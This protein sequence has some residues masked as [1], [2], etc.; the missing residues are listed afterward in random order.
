MLGGGI[1]R[2]CAKAYANARKELI[3]ICSLPYVVLTLWLFISVSLVTEYGIG[4]QHSPPV[5]CALGLTC[6]WLLGCSENGRHKHRCHCSYV[7]QCE[8]LQYSVCLQATKVVSNGPS[9]GD[10][11][12][13]KPYPTSTGHTGIICNCLRPSAPF[14]Y[15]CPCMKEMGRRGPSVLR[16]AMRGADHCMPCSTAIVT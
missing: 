5:L 4:V 10:L 3:W 1:R 8:L 9:E 14:P 2:L 11:L 13:C 7:L 15:V 16:L 12:R 6:V